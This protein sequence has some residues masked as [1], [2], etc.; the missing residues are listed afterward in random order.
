MKRLLPSLVCLALLSACG[1][2]PP[3][4]IPEGVQRVS[5]TLER[6][7]L[8]LSRRGT[9]LLRQQ[10]VALYFVESSQVN[11]RMQE[12]R[13][14]ELQGIVE[15]N[16]DPKELPVLVVERVLRGAEEGVKSWTVASLGVSL[17]V[18]KSWQG[19]AEAKSMRFTRSGS[20]LPILRV[21]QESSA[22]LTFDWTT[23]KAATGSELVVEPVVIDG[24]KGA[25]V[26]SAQKKAMNVHVDLGQAA[27][28]RVT[29][30]LLTLEFQ[31]DPRVDPEVEL[32]DFKR[33]AQS[34]RFGPASRA[35]SSAAAGSAASTI[36]S[37]DEGKPCGGPAGVLCPAGLYCQITDVVS[38]IGK[39]KKI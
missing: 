35:P 1:T 10:G 9:H 32:R 5:G 15:L 20:A 25:S 4:A 29:Q 6:A 24:H 39:C 17:D 12:G 2:P 16:T 22:D 26:Y 34:L 33:I 28:G 11:L 27:A 38:N 3:V 21:F 36:G 14:V 13:D 7:E 19:T 8:S 18:P 37:A 23:L 31:L 30:L